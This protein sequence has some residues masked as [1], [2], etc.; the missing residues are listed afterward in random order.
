M[1]KTLENRLQ[2]LEKAT[3]ETQ[4]RFVVNWDEDPLPPEE[5]TIVINWE[6]PQDEDRAKTP[7]D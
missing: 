7:T 5:G 2:Q 4:V 6:E 3:G 1:A